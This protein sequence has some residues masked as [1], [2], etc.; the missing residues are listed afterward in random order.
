MKAQKKCIIVFKRFNKYNGRSL[1]FSCWFIYLLFAFV[2][3]VGMLNI[4]SF[5]SSFLLQVVF[6]KK[7]AI[8]AHLCYLL[9]LFIAYLYDIAYKVIWIYIY[10]ISASDQTFIW[11]YELCF[12]KACIRKHWRSVRVSTEFGFWIVVIHTWFNFSCLLAS[13]Y[14][15]D[16][17]S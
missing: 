8:N 17:V 16:F 4:Y 14:Q 15:V 2:T 3:F 6:I 1:L 13:I 7:I 12:K 11:S 9:L 5:I 10:I